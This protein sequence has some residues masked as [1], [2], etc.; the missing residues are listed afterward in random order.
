MFFLVA[1][2]RIKLHIV[3]WTGNNF[4][5]GLRVHL[6]GFVPTELIG[7]KYQLMSFLL[8]HL[9]EHWGGRFD[10]S[11]PPLG[12]GF[13]SCTKYVLNCNKQIFDLDIYHSIMNNGYPPLLR[14]ATHSLP[15]VIIA[16][17]MHVDS[18]GHY[19]WVWHLIRPQFKTCYP[20]S[21]FLESPKPNFCAKI[22]LGSPSWFIT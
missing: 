15:C 20:F 18:I 12:F 11:R 21:S 22:W 16:S 14:Y 9:I 19:Y 13:K 6:L 17:R 3:H 10:L 4:G 2:C 7:G 1:S 5:F 8:N